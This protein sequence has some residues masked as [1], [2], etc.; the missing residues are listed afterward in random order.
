[1]RKQSLR[2]IYMKSPL[3]VFTIAIFFSALLPTQAQELKKQKAGFFAFE[4][5][6]YPA[7]IH[8]RT[9]AKTY[10]KVE[11]LGANTTS[12]IDVVFN[13]ESKAIHI[14]RGVFTFR[15]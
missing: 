5:P 1:M 10:Q 14:Y 11:L 2:L 4:L 15:Y 8:V 6:V 9:G 7:S 12:M 3:V 13:T